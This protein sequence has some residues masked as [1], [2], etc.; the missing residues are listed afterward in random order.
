M[1]ARV[2]GS[3]FDRNVSTETMIVLH[4]GNIVGDNIWLWR[5]GECY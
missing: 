3:S 4:S 5:A 2:G 1:F